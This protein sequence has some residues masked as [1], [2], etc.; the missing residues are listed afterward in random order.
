MSQFY[1][2]ACG[3]LMNSDPI[4]E[5]PINENVIQYTCSHCEAIWYVSISNRIINDNILDMD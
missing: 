1:C 2:E 4:E 5:Q 3:Y